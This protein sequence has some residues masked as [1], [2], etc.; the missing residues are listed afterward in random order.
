MHSQTWYADTAI[1]ESQEVLSDGQIME[2]QSMEEALISDLVKEWKAA[3]DSE[4]QS[5]MHTGVVELPTDWKCM[6]IQD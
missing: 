4:S 5:L 2:P 1:A 3:A 6:G